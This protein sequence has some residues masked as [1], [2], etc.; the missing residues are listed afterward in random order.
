MKIFQIQRYKYTKVHFTL[1]A[2]LV[3]SS[4][5][6]Y[7]ELRFCQRTSN[8][9]YK[10][11]T[12]NIQHFLYRMH[13]FG[14]TIS[15]A[16]KKGGVENFTKIIRKGILQIV[17]PTHFKFLKHYYIFIH[18]NEKQIHIYCICIC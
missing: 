5:W 10:S 14:L 2:F 15:I 8:L 16:L 18:L 1:R 12:F 9:K 13:S 7:T 4:R 3:V 6:S 11:N 17:F